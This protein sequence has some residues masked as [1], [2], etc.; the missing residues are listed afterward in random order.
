MDCH[1][2]MAAPST[3]SLIMFDPCLI[4]DSVSFQGNF[5]EGFNMK[6]QGPVLLE[7]RRQLSAPREPSANPL[8]LEMALEIP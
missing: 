2:Q 6:S 1:G 8:A 7:F 5:G 4:H 3:G